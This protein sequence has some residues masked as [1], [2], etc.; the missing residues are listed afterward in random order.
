MVPLI[1]IA[2]T[3]AVLLPL[4]PAAAQDSCV[5]CF[6]GGSHQAGDKPLT[7]E[8]TTDLAFSRMALAGGG[9]GSASI[10]PQTGGRRV[11]GGMV[12]LGGV[13]I[14]GHGR[15]TGSPR[16]AVRL[17]LPPSITMTASNGATAELT[18]L[19][20]DLPANPVLDAGGT[21]EFSFGGQLRVHGNTGGNFR[22]RI[23]ISVDYN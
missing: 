21:L 3:L 6:D 9:D 22:G 11:A 15:I 14:Q 17:D 4:A 5:L 10:D 12:E 23:P 8:I 19:I 20:T 16:R 13:S 2:A 1:R 7:I 18:S